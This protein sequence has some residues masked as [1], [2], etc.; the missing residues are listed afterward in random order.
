MRKTKQDFIDFLESLQGKDIF[1]IH[2]ITNNEYRECDKLKTRFPE[3]VRYVEYIG[4]FLFFVN[5]GVR[6]CNISFEEFLLYKPIC[7]N[8]VETGSLKKE[9]LELFKHE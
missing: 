4:E 2:A 6:P 5:T 7:E 8:L 3:Y 1:E 9:V